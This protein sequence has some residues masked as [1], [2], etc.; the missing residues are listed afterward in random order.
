MTGACKCVRSS[1]NWHSL[2]E[3]F[4]WAGESVVVYYYKNLRM[5]FREREYIHNNTRLKCKPHNLMLC[6]YSV[7]N[8]ESYNSSYYSSG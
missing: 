1:S 4:F 7:N 8:A 5:E 3:C 2:G 6:G